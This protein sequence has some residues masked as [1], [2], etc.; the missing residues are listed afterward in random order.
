MSPV[1][2][3]SDLDLYCMKL[4]SFRPKD[5]QDMII[6]REGLIKKGITREMLERNYIRLYGSLYM[7]K[8]DMRKLKFTEA[9]FG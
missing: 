5:I 9:Q 4:V 3:A 2:T 6:I 1:Y 8:N 7:M